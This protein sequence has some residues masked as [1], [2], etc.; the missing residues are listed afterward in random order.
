M[1]DE[2]V[3]SSTTPEEVV[4]EEHS[5][6]GGDDASAETENTE[7]ATEGED[8]AKDDSPSSDEGDAA[9]AEETEEEKEKEPFHKIPRFQQLI[10]EKNELKAR[11]ESLEAMLAAREG[12]AAERGEDG[13]SFKD[14]TTIP[15]DELMD[16]YAE[17][18]KQFLA[19]LATQIRSEVMSEVRQEQEAIREAQAT[20]EMAKTFAKYESENPDFSEMWESGVLEAFMRDFPGHNAISAHLILT[21]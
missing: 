7:G 21:L 14:I 1:P 3:E 6:G 2:Q 20:R 8:E 16:W 18:P 12:A 9:E 4:A 19:N 5:S 13:E 15:D 10:S 17:N 11:V